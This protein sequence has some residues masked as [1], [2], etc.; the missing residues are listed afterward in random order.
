MCYNLYSR[1][2]MLLLS[3]IT[4]AEY[5]IFYIVGGFC[6][7]NKFY[8]FKVDKTTRTDNF[9]QHTLFQV[10]SKMNKLFT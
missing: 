9:I 7:R 2:I 1:D 5:V 8:F 10:Q 4:I 6:F 3:L